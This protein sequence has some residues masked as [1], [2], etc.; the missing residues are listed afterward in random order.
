MAIKPSAIMPIG[1]SIPVLGLLKDNEPINQ[2]NKNP[3][4]N[5]TIHIFFKLSF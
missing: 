4:M 5:N 1:N 3:P 2:K